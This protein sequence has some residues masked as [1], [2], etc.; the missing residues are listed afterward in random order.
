LTDSNA[1]THDRA[2]LITSSLGR[3]REDEDLDS[4]QSLPSLEKSIEE[5]QQALQGRPGVSIRRRLSVGFLLWFLASLGLAIA[6][7]VLISR[8]RNK[9]AFMEAATNYTFEIQQARRFEKNYFLYRTNLDDA[10]VHVQNAHAILEGERHDIAAVVGHS[11]T[12]TMA[13]HLQLY[14]NL[15]S[16][17]KEIERSNGPNGESSELT[18]I[19]EQLRE[20][21]AEMVTV[22]ED[23]VSEERRSVNS[24]L[25]MSQ[26]IPVAFLGILIL[27]IVYLASFISGQV[28][29]PLNRMMGYSRRIAHG[30]FT[31]ITP[32]KKYH[33]EFS[34]LAMAMNHM[35]HQLVH[36]QEMLMKAHKLKAVGTLTAGVAHELNNPI[37]NIILT[38]SM[39][40]EDFKELSED[41]CL[42]LVNDLVSQSE[43]AQKIVRNLLDFARESEV[44]LES[45]KV[46]DIVEETLRLA[47]NQIKLSKVKVEGE[48]DENVP[49]IY[50]DRQQLAEVFLNLVLNAL[51]AMPEGG[52]FKIKILNTQNRESVAIKFED[53][54][55]GIPKQH[56]R[57]IFDPFFTSKKAAK[58]TG[59][60]LSVSLGIIQKHGGDIHVE[61]EV[62]KGTVFTVLLPVAKVPAD[63]GNR[64]DSATPAV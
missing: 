13:R 12:E 54:G 4:Q 10:L 52:T 64:I 22:A 53:T 8:I 26:R 40:Q 30:D 57:D 28:L 17:L 44:E 47:S 56:L 35:I 37:N 42:E 34:E 46:Q 49:A 15:L 11:G 24:M 36:R 20:H 41:E 59:L 31:P 14:Q 38:A 6:S 63:I 43:R 55:V 7:I 61:S 19:E 58:G 3:P 48:M 2:S 18:E 9:V 1:E 60:G 45:H 62:G 16:R 25:L 23:L 33:D 51:D 27:L 39:L 5:A 32:R 50:G 21:G 29:A